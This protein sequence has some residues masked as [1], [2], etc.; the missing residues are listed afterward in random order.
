MGRSTKHGAKKKHLGTNHF[1]FIHI[2]HFHSH[3]SF[4]ELLLWNTSPN[5]SRQVFVGNKHE[6]VAYKQERALLHRSNSAPA[7]Q[8]CRRN[9][10]YLN[11]RCALAE[12][13]S[14]PGQPEQ[15]GQSFW[16][17]LRLSSVL[18]QLLGGF[19]VLSPSDCTSH[20]QQQKPDRSGGVARARSGGGI[21][22]GLSLW[23]RQQEQLEG[24]QGAET[25]EENRN[26]RRAHLGRNNSKIIQKFTKL[27]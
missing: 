18:S 25:R 16:F 3:S 4:H 22:A 15:P 26:Q 9:P 11:Q 13:G 6:R 17:S 21:Q 20:L 23:E 1:I 14:E 5:L 27:R 7:Q 2:H 10:E 19:R 24:P 12:L 8:G